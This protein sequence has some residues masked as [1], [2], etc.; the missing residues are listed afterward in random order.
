MKESSL[1]RN[2]IRLL[3]TALNGA[4]MECSG[5]IFAGQ[6]L[7][8]STLGVKGSQVQILSSRRYAGGRCIGAISAGQRAFRAI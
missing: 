3:R 5:A 2:G 4:V 7:I 6:T 1:C 8:G